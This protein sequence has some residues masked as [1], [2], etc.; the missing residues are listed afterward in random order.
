MKYIKLFNEEL[1]PSTYVNAAVKLK[2]YK[3]Y[4]RADNLENWASEVKSKE[5]NKKVKALR[6][7]LSERGTFDCTIYSKDE[8]FTGKF[9]IDF[10]VD[11]Y[12]FIDDASFAFIGKHYNR[13][14]KINSILNDE[15]VKYQYKF[16]VGIPIWLGFMP[17]DDKTLKEVEGLNLDDLYINQYGVIYSMS[18]NLGLTSTD[19]NANDWYTYF[20]PEQS[21][22]EIS[23]QDYYDILFS[24][25]RNAIK[26]KRLFTDMITKKSEL[27]DAIKKALDTASKSDLVP[28]NTYERIANSIS[29]RFSINNFYRD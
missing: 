2:D 27:S 6:D 21:Y 29:A 8:I 20:N 13:G 18:I 9:Y 19:R 24:D 26:F 25:R 11:D 14:E 16:S 17:V 3:H 22:L 23:S 15:D 4:D 12:S 10:D 7:K 5:H 28:N 1:N